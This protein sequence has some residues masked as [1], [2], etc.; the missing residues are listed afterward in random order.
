[1]ARDM[2]PQKVTLKRE[3]ERAQAYKFRNQDVN[4]TMVCEINHTMDELMMYKTYVGIFQ[5]NFNSDFFTG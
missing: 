1:M 5:T 2:A 4:N 3:E